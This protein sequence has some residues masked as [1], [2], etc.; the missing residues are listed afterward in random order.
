MEKPTLAFRIVTWL[1]RK[2]RPFNHIY[3]WGNW[4][5][6]GIAYDKQEDLTSLGYI[7][8]F[9]VYYGSNFRDWIWI[10]PLLTPNSKGE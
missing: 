3:R 6:V 10:T 2:K 4:N 9:R 1:F 5:A 8:S 7:N